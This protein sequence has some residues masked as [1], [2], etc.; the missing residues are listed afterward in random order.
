MIGTA[1]GEAAPLRC[2]AAP[3]GTFARW[4]GA[5]VGFGEAPIAP[6]GVRGSWLI[7][8]Q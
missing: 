3:T 5:S 1:R 4:A 6:G 2:S 8:V 7:L